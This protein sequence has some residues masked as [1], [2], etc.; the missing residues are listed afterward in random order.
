MTILQILEARRR[1]RNMI[2]WLIK[3]TGADNFDDKAR[4]VDNYRRLLERAENNF[5]KNFITG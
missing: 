4:A 3:Q 1:L 2:S 5:Y